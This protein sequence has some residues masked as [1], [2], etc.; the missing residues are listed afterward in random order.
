VETDIVR[1][2]QSGTEAD[3]LS[4]DG[5]SVASLATEGAERLG[6]A[7]EK[8]G[9]DS[10]RFWAISRVYPAP[11]GNM[12]R[13]TKTGCNVFHANFPRQS[14]ALRAGRKP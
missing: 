14:G 13:R 11:V 3:Q 7:T 6:E 1:S 5:S 12:V 2:L 8:M 10:V 9:S 4:G